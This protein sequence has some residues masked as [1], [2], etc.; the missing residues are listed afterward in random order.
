MIDLRGPIPDAMA[1]LVVDQPWDLGRLW[2]LALPTESLDVAALAWQLELPWW[3]EGDRAFA[4][5]P[6]QVRADPRRYAD[7]W[8]STLEADLRHPLVLVRRERSV[9]LDGLHRLLKAYHFGWIRIATQTVPAE[10]LWRIAPRNA[11]GAPSSAPRVRAG[12]GNRTPVS[13][14]GSSRSAIE[15]H[16]RGPTDRVGGAPV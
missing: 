11:D 6:A 15:P 1:P 12:E 5:S 16:P 3:R 9:V 8:R 7:H 13:S 2:S 14:L 10:A 4:V